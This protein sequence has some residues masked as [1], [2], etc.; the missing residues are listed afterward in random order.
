M[1][2]SLENRSPFLDRELF[3]FVSTIPS[4]YLI[5]KGYAKY[6]LREALSGILCDSVRL[7]YE[8]K[9]FNASIL[10]VFDI[11]NP[12]LR[13]WLLAD[14]PLLNIIK[15]DKLEQLITNKYFANSMSKFLF[16]IINTKIFLENY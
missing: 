1:Y 13:N 15:K 16:S 9:G 8:K 14:G 4:V 6:I 12:E 5:Q 11:N 2:Y 10:S 7:N 3:E